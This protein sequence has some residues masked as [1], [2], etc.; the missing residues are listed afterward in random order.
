MGYKIA[1]L[2][3]MVLVFVFDTVVHSLK[4]KSASRPIP[5]NVADVYDEKAYATWLRYFGE[6]GKLSL[7]RYLV[8]S[9]FGFV[10]I[11]FNVYALIDGLFGMEGI[12]GA[13]CILVIA[14]SLISLIGRLPFDYAQDMGIEQRYGFNRMTK[15]IFFGDAVKNLVIN[16]GLSCALVC[17]L[18]CL[19]QWLGNLLVPAFL[20]V[21][22]GFTLLMTFLSPVLTR[23]F[24]KLTPLEEG[25]LREKLQN[26][27]DTNH[28][29]VRDIYVMDGSKRSTKANA[30][31][32]GFGKMKTIALYD[33]LIE[34]MTPDEIVAVFA[35]EMGHNKHRD[36]LKLT[37]LNMVNF[38]LMGL[39]LWALVSVPEI[40]TAFGFETVNYGFAF[41]LLSVCFGALS[42]FVSL[43]Q[44]A[45]SR[46]AEYA[47]DRFAA[48]AGYGDVLQTGLKKL[49]RANF[50]CLNPHPV[51]VKLYY[52]HPTTSQ[53]LDAL[54]RLRKL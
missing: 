12:Y 9:L 35:H 3:I 27:L 16:L 6:C 4:S 2:A 52:S 43:L 8:S 24:N 19:H 40:Y 17:V 51:L 49:E 38:V 41:V 7:R 1:I 45:M 30:F 15:K 11:G 28:C 53:R 10:L 23:I 22:L 21:M 33:T 14:D 44:S 32:S 5:E 50:G 47:A 26:L 29:R 48:D 34:Q 39:I 18:I 36:T 54:T 20:V 42:P 31:F 25:E 13:A 37:A 46:K